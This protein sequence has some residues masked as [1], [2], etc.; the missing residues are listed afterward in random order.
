[1]DISEKL[2]FD[3]KIYTLTYP[4]CTKC[5]KKA[6]YY[7]NTHGKRT[8]CKIHK[9][10]HHLKADCS[11]KAIPDMAGVIQNQHYLFGYIY[12]II[13][14]AKELNLSEVVTDVHNMLD[15]F[16]TKIDD[17]QC[18]TD[19][20]IKEGIYENYSTIEYQTDQL[21]KEL[22]QSTT[23][24]DIS[25][26]LMQI[27]YDDNASTPKTNGEN[28]VDNRT[29]IQAIDYLERQQEV[30]RLRHA[31]AKLE[32][33]K[34]HDEYGS[35]ENKKKIAIAQEKYNEIKKASIKLDKD[36]KYVINMDNVE[37]QRILKFTNDAKLPDIKQLKIDRL[38][39]A[40]DYNLEKFLR[41]SVPQS[42]QL[43]CF[44]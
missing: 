13:L 17:L 11:V 42:I 20:A 36:F 33:Q 26:E 41:Y 25:M 4:R 10:K 21:M 43:F 7:C 6:E 31:L 2:D 35:D 19:G 29:G 3:G 22:H 14:K 32:E 24:R 27:L 30:D 9:F 1:M 16:K 39:E 23:V 37:D 5:N 34:H 15:L 40:I 18:I 28:N 38:T 8:L 44:N 12:D